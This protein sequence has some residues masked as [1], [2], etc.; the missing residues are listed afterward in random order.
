MKADHF[1][2]TADDWAKLFVYCWLPDNADE[3][4][5]VVHI[6][7]GLAEHAARYEAVAAFLTANGYAVYANDHRGHGHS[8]QTPNEVGHFADEDGWNRI[9]KDLVLMCTE[10]KQTYEGLPLILLGH[11][12]GAL[13]AQ[14][15]AY[16]QGD[17]FDAI[18][19]SGPNGK[20]SGLAQVG[21]LLARFERWRLGKRGRSRLIN[22]LSFEAFNKAFVPART[23]F[24]WL[25]RDDAEV[26]RY[27]NDP[28]C[29]FICTTQT[30]VDLLDAVTEIAKPENRARVRKDLPLYLFS[31]HRDVTNEFGIGLET[32]VAAYRKNNVRSIRFKLYPDARHEVFNEINRTEVLNDLL[33]WLNLVVIQLGEKILA[34]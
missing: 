24:D 4:K 25:S 1:T 2:F 12:M 32:L 17:L 27:I 26:D 30:W 10:E 16:E 13:L 15:M 3:V 33:D 22:R 7:H 8:A 18:A 19:M 31:G 5:A 34:R 14:Q 23:P 29:G 28:L 21:K 6:A 11:S 20:V 9:A